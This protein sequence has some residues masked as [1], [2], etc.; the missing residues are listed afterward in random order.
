MLHGRVSPGVDLKIKSVY[1]TRLSTWAYDKAVWYK[2][3]YPTGLVWPS[4]RH[5]TRAF[6]AIA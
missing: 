2:S 6:V 1:F 4:T 5:G 3:V